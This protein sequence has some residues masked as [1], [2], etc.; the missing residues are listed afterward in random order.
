MKL[1]RGTPC[2][3][4]CIGVGLLLCLQATAADKLKPYKVPMLSPEAALKSF[5]VAD[6][7]RM[8]LV[9]CEP[10][11]EEP[12]A[13]AWDGNGRMYVAEM[14]TYMQDIDGRDQFRPISRVVR[15]EDT[16]GDGRMDKHTV[17]VDKL[18]LPRMILPLEKEV[19]IRET[20]TLDLWA[21]S[22]HDG[23]GVAD[24]KKLWHKGGG[25]GGN[26]EHQPSG[27]LWNIDNWIYTTYSNHRYRVTR[28]KVERHRLPAGSGQWGLTHDAVG[29]LYYSTA[30]GEPPSLPTGAGLGSVR[31]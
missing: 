24:E 3:A 7:Y 16:D 26:L 28:G 19:I 5:V 31:T 27:L 30:G 9:A 1:L 25:R 11:I 4:I 13:L 22:E 10:M 12:V 14:R 8:E 6:G 2:S 21:Y 23:D 17:F 29:K 18:V 20:N 15:M